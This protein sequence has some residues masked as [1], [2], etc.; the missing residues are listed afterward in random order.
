MTW[1]LTER[2]PQ[3]SAST[4]IAH[5]D[6]TRRDVSPAGPVAEPGSRSVS[7]RDEQHRLALAELDHLELTRLARAVGVLQ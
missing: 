6:A 5:P 4:P 1:L 3:A 2:E 7:S